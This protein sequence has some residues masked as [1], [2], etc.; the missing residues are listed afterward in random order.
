MQSAMKFAYVYRDAQ[1]QKPPCIRS[2]PVQVFHDL[3]AIKLNVI[4]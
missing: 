3:T 4:T 1:I 2:L